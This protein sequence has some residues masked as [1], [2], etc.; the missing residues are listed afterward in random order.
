MEAGKQTV[1]LDKSNHTG[2]AFSCQESRTLS[3]LP[4]IQILVLESMKAMERESLEAINAGLAKCTVTPWSGVAVEDLFKII[5]QIHE[6]KSSNC[7]TFLTVGL[8]KKF[9]R[10]QM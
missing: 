9:I 3:S 4:D 5:M 7:F 2:A 1:V 10:H 8:I 6:E